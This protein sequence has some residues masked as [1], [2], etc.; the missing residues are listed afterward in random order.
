MNIQTITTK[1]GADKTIVVTMPTAIDSY[2]NILIW[3]VNQNKDPLATPL[4]FSLNT[5]AGHTTGYI[6]KTDANKVTFTLAALYTKTM[7]EGVYYIDLKYILT[8]TPE[9]KSAPT[10]LLLNIE[11]SALK[12]V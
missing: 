2:S 5:I 4:K 10:I 11:K 1:Q 9:M 3:V 8:G 7:Q 12:D 6:T